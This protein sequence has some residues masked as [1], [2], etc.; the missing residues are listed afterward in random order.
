[1]VPERGYLV[2]TI[3]AGIVEVTAQ[4]RTESDGVLGVNAFPSPSVPQ[5]KPV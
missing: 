1:V 4:V 5:S 3:A 2:V